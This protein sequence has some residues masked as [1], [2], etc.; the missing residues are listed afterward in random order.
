MLKVD[1]DIDIFTTYVAFVLALVLVAYVLWDVNYFVRVI[2][3]VGR[4]RFFQDKIKVDETS[5]IYGKISIILYK[6][7]TE[8]GFILI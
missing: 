1:F 6:I 8:F 4:G 2:F 7:S 5:T 3:T